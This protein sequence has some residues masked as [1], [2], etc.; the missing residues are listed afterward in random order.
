MRYPLIVIGAIALTIVTFFIIVSLLTEPGDIA[1]RERQS[2]TVDLVVVEKQRQQKQQRTE[3][4]QRPPV[5]VSTPQ[6]E[7]HEIR[8]QVLP[9]IDASLSQVVPTFNLPSAVPPVLGQAST[10]PQDSDAVP[11]LRIEP[12]Y[13]Q[14]A[15]RGGLE[16]WVKL[17]FTVNVDGSVSGAKVL[18]SEPRRVFDRAA[19]QS[20]A[21]WK[22]KPAIKDGVAIS[23]TLEQIIDFKITR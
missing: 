10:G 15:L 12:V 1:D 8:K 14:K 3:L 23:V 21:R 2:R 18:A 11:V 5:A 13:P 9:D 17:G 4:E 19:L 16:G 22:F 7:T 6:I 20:I